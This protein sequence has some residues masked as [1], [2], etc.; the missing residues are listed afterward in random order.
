[1]PHPD[2]ESLMFGGTLAKYG[3]DKRIT[4]CLVTVTRG[5]LGN[6]G[7]PKLGATRKTIAAVRERELRC[8]TAILNVNRLHI[9]DYQD[10]ELSSVE[11]HIGIADMVR[12]IQKIKPQVIITFGPDGGYGHPDHVALSSW[13][14]EAVKRTKPV[15]K[16]Y[17][18]AIKKDFAT[19]FIKHFGKIPLNGELLEIAV[20]DESYI[21]TTIDCRKYLEQKFAAIH[22]HQSQQQDTKK[23]DLLRKLGVKTMISQDHYH[24]ALSRGNFPKPETD[25]FAGL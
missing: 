13:V 23:F 21:D 1:M 8:A 24:L 17:Y 2:D 18:Y 6:L 7:P 19:N 25:L 15:K 10:G 14:T 22:C 3:Q 12:L 11:E 4:T 5:E 20:H 9:L 16:L